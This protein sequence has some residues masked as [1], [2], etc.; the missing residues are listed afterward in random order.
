MCSGRCVDRICLNKS[1]RALEVQGDNSGEDSDDREEGGSAHVTMNKYSQTSIDVVELLC[2]SE[3]VWRSSVRVRSEWRKELCIVSGQG[4]SP[5]P[6]AGLFNG[7]C[8]R[9][10]EDWGGDAP[11]C[12]SSHYKTSHPHLLS[13]QNSE[14]MD[15]GHW[16]STDSEH[17]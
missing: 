2:G 3:W 1:D 9:R 13:A 11:F 8:S 14:A 4:A 5:L 17:W 10:Q 12:P 15:Y 6:F 7:K 16:E